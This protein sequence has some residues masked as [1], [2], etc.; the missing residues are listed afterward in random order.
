MTSFAGLGLYRLISNVRQAELR[1]FVHDTLGPVLELPEPARTDL[2]K[3]LAVLFSTRF[4]VA[5]SARALHYHY[6]TMRY[7]VTK[8]ERMLGGFT[9]D[10]AAALRI[11]VALQVLR[12][13]EISGDTLQTLP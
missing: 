9:G 7:R 6:N 12:M 8:L 13:Y 10:A 3:S 2:L 1:A 5:E 4:N 11:G